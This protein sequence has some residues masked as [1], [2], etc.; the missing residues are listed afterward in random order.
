MRDR[1]RTWGKYGNR[2]WPV[3]CL[4]MVGLSWSAAAER[5]LGTIGPPPR[6]DPQRQT[7]AEGMP[8]LPLGR[9]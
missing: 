6:Q 4:A 8:P 3:A 2:I 1:T 5:Q 7:A 9:C